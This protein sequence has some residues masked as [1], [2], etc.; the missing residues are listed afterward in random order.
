MADQALLNWDEDT[1]NQFRQSIMDC[2]QCSEEEAANRLQATIQNL[3]GAPNPP[4]DPPATPP[5]L[6]TPPPPPHDDESQPV[7]KKKVA[8]IDFDLDTIVTDRVPHSPYQ[9]AVGRI[10]NMEYVELWYFTAEGCKEASKATPTTADD[11][12]GLLNTDTGL[13]LQSIKATKASPNAIADES[14]S[15]NQI[16]TARHTMIKTANHAGWPS[17]HTLALAT[18]Y[19]TLESMQAEGC[20]PRALI[21]Y[22]AVIQRLWHDAMK[23]KGQ[24]F[25]PG[26]FNE[27]LYTKLENKVRDHDQEETQRK[28]SNTH[29]L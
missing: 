17:K 8:Y 10:E 3:V 25:N 23:G 29:R 16:M 19:I 2:F 13:T 28:A 26:I 6:E 22:H 18:F 4:P 12:F 24:P 27:K 7:P 11:T 15:W 14:L 20:N 9:Y 5:R 21:L 1:F